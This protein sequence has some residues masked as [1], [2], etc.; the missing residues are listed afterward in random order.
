MFV[1]VSLY[2]RYLGA[3][4]TVGAF[5]C[6]QL[7][8]AAILDRLGVL[9]LDQISLSPARI[10]PNATLIAGTILVSIR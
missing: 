6:A 3:A 4:T 9:G 5:L 8:V 1:A 10:L 2:V 7:I